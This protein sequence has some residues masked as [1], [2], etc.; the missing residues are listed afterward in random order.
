[1]MRVLKAGGLYFALVFAAGFV[2][3]SIRLLWLV[4]RFGARTAELM[5]A[6]IMLAAIVAAARWIAGRPGAPSTRSSRL[7]MGC[8]ALGLLLTAEFTWVLWL[9]ALSIAAY[10]AGRDPVSGTVYYA[11]LGVFAVMPLLMGRS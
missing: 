9:R 4:P 11:M 10:L 1:M 7:G 5:E 3:G 6:P 2:M 8:L